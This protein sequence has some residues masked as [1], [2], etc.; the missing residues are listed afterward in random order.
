[1]QNA[2]FYGRTQEELARRTQAEVQLT[3]LLR[4]KELLLREIHHRVKNNL[5]IIS[6]LLDL[7]SDAIRDTGV[8][9]L[10]KDSQHRIHSMAL[11]HEIL[12]QSPDLAWVDV[13]A[14]L[15][16]LSAQLFRSY[17]VDARRITLRTHTDR[18]L[19]D[20]DQA[21]PCGLILNELLTNAFKYA[22][23]EDRTGEVYVALHADPPQHVTIVV[24]DT[25]IGLPE[26]LDFRNTDSFGLQLVCLLAE[27]MEGTITLLR[28]QGTTFT[29]TFPGKVP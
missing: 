15:Q 14:Y 22:F 16:R 24:Q 19:L 25:G 27:Q 17:G 10:F 20:I 11:V 28:E 23:P 7:H 9:A 4:E 26:G 18:V 1:M 6:S 5:Q 3:G 13:G 12:Y 8:L 29:L 21:I 2:E